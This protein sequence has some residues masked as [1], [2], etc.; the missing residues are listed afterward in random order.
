[1]DMIGHQLLKFIPAV[2][3]NLAIGINL[4]LTF[5][6]ITILFAVIFKVLP[7]ARI[8]W[9]DVIVGSVTTSVL[10]M[11]GKFAIGYYLGSSHISTTYG[12]AG[13]LIII[14]LWVYY[15]AASLYFGATFTRVFARFKG[16]DIYPDDDAVWIKEIE[17]ENKDSILSGKNETE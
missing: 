6:T 3:L 10:F 1:M 2:M 9:R 13:S 8:K 11:S 5:F 14:L 12:A 4:F 16:H 15:S 17:L 7:D